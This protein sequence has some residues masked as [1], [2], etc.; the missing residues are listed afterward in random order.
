[1]V[2][3]YTNF[4]TISNKRKDEYGIKKEIRLNFSLKIAK[5]IRKIWPKDKIL[6]ARITATDHLNGGIKIKDSIKLAK[7]LK[8][9]GFD[10]G[11]SKNMKAGKQKI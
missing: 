8:K 7:E 2:I 11:L 3:Y 10:Y 1:M 6:G 4:C 5:G 9:I